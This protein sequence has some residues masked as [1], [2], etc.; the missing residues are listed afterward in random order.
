VT[1]FLVLFLAS[2]AYSFIAGHWLFIDGEVM[3]I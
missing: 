1:L 3:A 2:D